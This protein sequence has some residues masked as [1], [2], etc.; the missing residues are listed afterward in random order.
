MHT[1]YFIISILCF[2]K[3]KKINKGRAIFS[4]QNVRT[5]RRFVLSMFACITL[6]KNTAVSKI[7]SKNTST[8]YNE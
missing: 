3:I 5:G 6:M 2:V 7:L 4:F 8:E 1:F